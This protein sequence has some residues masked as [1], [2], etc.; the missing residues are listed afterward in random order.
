MPYS[1]LRLTDGATIATTVQLANTFLLRLTGLMG[2]SALPAQQGLWITPCNSVHSCFM[3]FLFDAVF[4]DKAGCIVHL[5]ENMPPWQVT[6]LIKDAKA[7][8]ELPGGSIKA[9]Q[10]QLGDPL[11]LAQL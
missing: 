3:R 4:V 2:K 10:L 5:V 6:P 9:H 7:V 8:L 1:V 11:K